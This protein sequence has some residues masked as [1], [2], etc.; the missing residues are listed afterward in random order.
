MNFFLQLGQPADPAPD[1]PKQISTLL[2]EQGCDVAV[3]SIDDVGGDRVIWERMVVR[4]AWAC[5]VSEDTQPMS[6]MCVYVFD[7]VYT[8]L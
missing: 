5:G 2:R 6:Y 4:L 1:M 3:L 7:V 8:S